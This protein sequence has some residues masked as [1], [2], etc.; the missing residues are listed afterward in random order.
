MGPEI[1]QLISQIASLP[2]D[3]HGAGTVGVNVLLAI[4]G[5]MEK[6]GIIFQSV[7]TGLG[8]T[9]LLLSHLSSSHFV[10]AL[11]SGESITQVKKSPLFNPKN[12]TFIEGPSQRTLPQYCFPD[13]NDLVLID[14][15]H[16]YPF[17]DL[18]YFYLYPTLKLGGLLILDDIMIP[19]IRRMF[20]ILIADKMY[21]LVNI[22]D[23]NTAFFKRTNA[24]TINPEG[25][26]WWLQGY[27]EAFFRFRQRQSSNG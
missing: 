7:E 3:W 15:P 26:D 8:R 13:F 6:Y 27:N 5:Y 11:D 12:V 21:Q 10:F 17:P 20:D 22:L 1:N 25:D 9:T 14:G 24:P 16:G 18:E 19:T 2:E 23:G 4:T